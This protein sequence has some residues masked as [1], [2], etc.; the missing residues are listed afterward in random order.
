[1]I[2]NIKKGLPMNDNDLVLAPVAAEAPTSGDLPPPVF[3][4]RAGETP[5]AFSAFLAYFQQGQTRSL[6]AVAD[7]LGEGLG[8]VKNWSSQH[9]WAGRLQ[10]FHSGLLSAQARD[11]AARQLR[12]AADWQRRLDELREQEWESSQKLSIAAQCFLETLGEDDLR[13]MTLAQA[14]R[15]LKISSAIARSA[16]AGLELPA[17]PEAELSLLQRQLLAGVERVYGQPPLSSAS[18]IQQPATSNQQPVTRNQN[19][20]KPCKN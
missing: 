3:P 13:R 1:M 17:S 9:D 16:L 4:R 5:R 10:A 14:S 20:G 12:P 8:T 6:S 18:S 7:Q 19:I 11:H 2:Y 15:A